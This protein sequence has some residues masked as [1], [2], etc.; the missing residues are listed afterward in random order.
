ME[1]KVLGRN[2]GGDITMYNKVFSFRREMN[3]YI[4]QIKLFARARFFSFLLYNKYGSLVLSS[5]LA[6]E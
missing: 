5:I 2:N 6:L 4:P 1:K 3:E